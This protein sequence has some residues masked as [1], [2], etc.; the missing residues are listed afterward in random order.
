MA[1]NTPIG[2]ITQI[3]PITSFTTLG[4]VALDQYIL[5]INNFVQGDGSKVTLKNLIASMVNTT[6]TKNILGIDED[7]KLQAIEAVNPFGNDNGWAVA[8][9]LT[10]NWT[11]RTVSGSGGSAYK[12]GFQ[13][14]ALSNFTS[15]A[16]SAN[17]G[18]YWLYYN[19]S[20]NSFVWATT[21]PDSNYLIAEIVVNADGTTK[22]ANIAYGMGGISPTISK[23][24]NEALGTIV[25]DGGE[26]SNVTTNVEIVSGG[27]LQPHVS[28]TQVGTVDFNYTISALTTNSFTR[29]HVAN[30]TLA[31]E[32]AQSGIVPT[33]NDIIPVLIDNTG[34]ET[35]LAIGCYENIWLVG[36]PA[37][38][39]NPSG[40]KYQF[41]TGSVQY[42]QLND[43][44]GA[45]P[46]DEISMQYIDGAYDRYAIITRFTIQRTEDGYM[47]VD[48]KKYNPLQGGGGAGGSGITEVI[49]DP[50]YFSGLGLPSNPLTMSDATKD[51]L[52]HVVHDKDN[53]YKV[54]QGHKSH[55]DKIW[56]LIE[57]HDPTDKDTMLLGNDSRFTSNTSNADF[58]FGLLN[59]IAGSNQPSDTTRLIT[60]Q[61]F[62]KNN[63]DNRTSTTGTEAVLVNDGTLYIASRKKIRI[64]KR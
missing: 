21:K 45:S 24:L 16:F 34:T 36:L 53:I 31:Y 41:A 7:G 60:Y 46:L 5:G 33:H 25:L 42:D 37:F 4:N 35:E 30:N 11:N 44:K 10:V 48:Y 17:A 13:I 61:L 18:H 64:S 54:I 19:T 12:D 62:N 52:D 23:F 1:M 26:I 27:Y 63:W 43:A 40:I 2:N 59:S 9:T 57:Y 32:T 38:G 56:D 15:P 28:A 14:T 20:N 29:V 51:I 6:N 58:H 49:S 22:I 3:T 50:D 39:E 47:C 55:D 8:P